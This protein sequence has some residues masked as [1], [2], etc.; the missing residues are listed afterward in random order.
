MGN[1]EA[2]YYGVPIIGM[3]FF[4]DQYLIIDKAVKNGYGLSLLYKD[5]TEKTLKD[6][7]NS[8]LY[9]PSFAKKAK[10]VSARFRDKPSSPMDTAIFWLEY[11]I[12][13]GGSDHMRSPILNLYWYEYLYLDVAFILIFGTVAAATAVYFFIVVLCKLLLFRKPSKRKPKNKKE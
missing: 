4:G 7:L 8:I 1:Q 5:V 6:T 3:P 9:D 2:I 13:N 10:I 11:V 12:R